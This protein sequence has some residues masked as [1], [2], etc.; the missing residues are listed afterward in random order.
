MPCPQCQRGEECVGDPTTMLLIHDERVDDGP[1]YGL[2]EI[3]CT[4]CLYAAAQR[5]ATS[6][7][8]DGHFHVLGYVKSMIG[9]AVFK[10]FFNDV[11]NVSL[12]IS[13]HFGQ[14]IFGPCIFNSNAPQP[15]SL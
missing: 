15:W 3:F 5:D 11:L 4:S 13:A 14:L 1:E 12:S 8:W 6:W 9:L 10:L 7:F 2:G